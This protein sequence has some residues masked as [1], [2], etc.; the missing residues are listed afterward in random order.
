M[1][2]PRIVLKPSH[3]RTFTT[4]DQLAAK[5]KTCRSAIDNAIARWLGD[6]PLTSMFE[7][8]LVRTGKRGPATRAL[9]AK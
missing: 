8:K 9:R 3:F 6:A 1:A 4:L 7:V 2:K 5:L